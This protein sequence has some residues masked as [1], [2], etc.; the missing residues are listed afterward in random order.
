MKKRIKKRMKKRINA[1]ERTRHL[2]GYRQLP[3]CPSHTYANA[4]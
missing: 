4:H 3:S 2:A 1:K